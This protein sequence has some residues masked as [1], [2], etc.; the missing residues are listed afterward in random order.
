[1]LFDAW[2][3][4]YSEKRKEGNIKKYLNILYCE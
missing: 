2:E 4:K 3:C 1:M